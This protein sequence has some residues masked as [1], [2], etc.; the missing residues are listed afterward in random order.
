MINFF[1]T[2]VLPGIPG[3]SYF[4]AEVPELAKYRLKN[5]QT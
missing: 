2:L 1:Q 4:T 5:L 3:S